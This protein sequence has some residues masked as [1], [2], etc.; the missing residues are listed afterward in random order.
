[1]VDS[2]AEFEAF[3]SPGTIVASIDH[4]GTNAVRFALMASLL[5]AP[6]EEPGRRPRAVDAEG[7][8]QFGINP[9]LTTAVPDENRLSRE[10]SYLLTSARRGFDPDELR[11]Q[12]FDAL[13]ADAGLDARLA[14]LAAGLNSTL[15]RESAVAA[16]AI[17]TSVPVVEPPVTTA[18]W[19]GWPH[20][21]LDR[22]IDSSRFGGMLR[23]FSSPF[24]EDGESEN[25]LAWEGSDWENYC[26]YWLRDVFSTNDTQQVLAGLRFLAQV[27]VDVGQ[28]SADPIVREL[29]LAAYLGRQDPGSAPPPSPPQEHE[30]IREDIV[31]TMVHGTRGWKGTWWYPGG[32]FH[33]YVTED[34]RPALYAGGQEFSWSGAYS[35]SQRAV[36]GDRFA[37]WAAGAGGP[38]GL[39]AVFA[40]SYGAEV[41]ARAVNSGTLVDEV[42]L[43]SAPIHRHHTNM[44]RS[45]RRA[46]DVRLRFDIV[47]LAARAHQRLPRAVNV[48][49]HV[50]NRHFWS[51]GATHD[52]A[53]WAAEG[54]AAAVGL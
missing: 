53:V 31:S 49:E 26:S 45:V 18:G 50:V 28:R 41:V 22:N 25:S 51:H 34:V 42:V 39:G 40:H 17:L 1:M 30:G 6:N 16:A 11:Q 14:L 7:L 35:P 43:L 29:S 32:D 36:A 24:E 20:R 2:S 4:E 21:F 15:E 48:T 47:L 23:D 46:I 10:A 9:E 54:I 5:P 13:N 52:P 33:T 38:A 3:S 27:R 37:R 8:E 44:L 12:A 19:R